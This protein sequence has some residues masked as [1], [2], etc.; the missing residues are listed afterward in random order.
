MSVVEEIREQQ[1]KALK[2]MNNKEKLAYFWDYYKVHTLVAV[3]VIGLTAMFIYQYATNRDYGF[4]AAIINADATRLSETDSW[5]REFEEYVEMDTE[6]YQAYIDTSIML[7]DT[8]SSQYS[9]SN[10]EKLLAMMQTGIVDVIVTDTATFEKYAQN[11][12]F[13][14][15]EEA[16]PADVYNKYK[17]CL[18]YTDAATVDMGD[19]DTFHTA[20]E[21]INPDTYVINHRDPST[22]KK[23][24]P[25]GICLPE[26]NKLIDSGCFDYLAETGV[27]YQSYP[28]E[29]VF[30]IPITSERSDIALQFLEFLEE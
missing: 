26:G 30:G 25:V 3:V 13:I 8:D 29:A 20:D 28:S 12:Y 22:M 23:P 6:E 24:V 1:K 10:T 4:Y 11:E 18:Y 9:L 21:I 27:T 17:D 19:D 2:E 14:N 5:N 15:L 16:L 7:S